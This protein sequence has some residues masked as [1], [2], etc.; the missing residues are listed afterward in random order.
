M[1]DVPSLEAASLD[2]I[3]IRQL[4]VDSSVD[5]QESTNTDASLFH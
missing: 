4:R 5:Q 1:E 2:F 3:F